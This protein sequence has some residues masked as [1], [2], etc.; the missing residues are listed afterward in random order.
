MIKISATTSATG[1][2]TKKALC[3][4]ANKWNLNHLP[5]PELQVVQKTFTQVLMP[6]MKAM[7]GTMVPWSELSI[8]HVQSLIDKAFSENMHV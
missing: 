2:V 1:P 8:V 7:V 3:G 5:G 4:G 6:L